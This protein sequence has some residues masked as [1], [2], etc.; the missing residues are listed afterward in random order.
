MG[1]PTLSLHSDDIV[2][3]MAKADQWDDDAWVLA[4][5]KKNKRLKVVAEFG[6]ER[7]LGIGYA[8]MSSNISGYLRTA[9]GIEGS[10]K[11][12]GVC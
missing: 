11:R 3:F 8:Y 12:Q 4:V 1:H 9:P 7:T 5:D 10:L 2:C 6:A